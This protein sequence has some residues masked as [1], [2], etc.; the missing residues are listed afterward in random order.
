[1]LF[2][3]LQHQMSAELELQPF[4]LVKPYSLLL[5]VA[6]ATTPDNHAAF[7]IEG[8][9][10]LKAP[11]ISPISLSEFLFR[12]LVHATEQIRA[13]ELTHETCSNYCRSIMETMR[14]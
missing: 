6:Q 11:R 13:S 14:L 3:P 4:L 5:A 2:L 9:Q 7:A 8:L 1:M 12:G 10:E